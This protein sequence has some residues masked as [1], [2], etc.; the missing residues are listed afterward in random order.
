MSEEPLSNEFTVDPNELRADLQSLKDLAKASSEKAGDL[1]AQKTAL[2]DR[3]GYHKV[4]L[5]MCLKI[6]T[7][8]ETN[9][10]DFLRT[11]RPMFEAMLPTWQHADMLD[12]LDD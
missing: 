3:K 9:Q 12:G 1:G 2:V 5:G 4:A 11:F 8:S 10:A 6:D 7:M